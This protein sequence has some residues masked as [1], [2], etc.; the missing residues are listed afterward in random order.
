MRVLM[1]GWEYPP[2]ITGGLGNACR[3]LA[4]ALVRQGIHV[5]FVMPR[6]DSGTP[7]DDGVDTLFIDPAQSHTQSSEVPCSRPNEHV[8]PADIESQNPD[9]NRAS[10]FPPPSDQTI[11]PITASNASQS[12]DSSC[13]PAVQVWQLYIDTP[14][15]SVY[16]GAKPHAPYAAP[17]NP[18]IPIAPPTPPALPRTQA[19][20]HAGSILQKLFSLSPSS[21]QNAK[22]KASSS[23]TLDPEPGTRDFPPLPYPPDAVGG[24][25]AFADTVVQHLLHDPFDLIHANDWVTFPA[26]L[27][28]GKA[29]GVPVVLHVHSLE[30]DRSP[31]GE[32]L[33]I[34]RIESDSVALASAVIAVS[35][36]TREDLIREY[37]LDPD[38]AFVV[39]NG[40]ELASVW[41]NLG[42]I[43]RD[44]ED[45]L[46]SSVLFLGRI[47]AQKGPIEF[48]RACSKVA[49]I[50]PSTSF[51]IAGDGDLLPDCKALAKELGLADRITFTGFLSAQQV[52]DALDNTDVLVMPSLS[53][54]FGLVVLEAASRGV[55]SIVS[56]HAGVAEAM[57]HLVTC[58]PD[59]TF[60]LADKILAVLRHPD[61]R[62][63]LRIGARAELLRL[64]WD[65]GA[66]RCLNVYRQINK[67]TTRF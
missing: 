37:A 30:R 51:V 15:Q 29:W 4:R 36:H 21:T 67:I 47:T 38:R 58:D 18:S 54:P 40:V 8:F 16:P 35:R 44:D 48:L 19:Q 56:R 62:E 7:V 60:D 2:H 43:H 66:Q 59:N 33:A 13:I 23:S 1:L 55:P 22:L 65:A 31:L 49:Q 63:E 9:P 57:N 52:Q 34:R 14:W 45:R 17:I 12:S 61:M 24:A 28:L 50:L 10:A 46:G 64:S 6:P 53:E 11:S 20:S 39:Y 5:R 25:R 41:A 42:Q 3:G 27:A 26:A 32:N